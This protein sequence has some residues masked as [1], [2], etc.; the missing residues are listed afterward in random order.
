MVVRNRVEPV[1]HVFKQGKRRHKLL[2]IDIGAHQ[3]TER[4]SFSSFQL[5]RHR[6][7][8]GQQPRAELRVA[9]IFDGFLFAARAVAVDL[10]DVVA[11]LAALGGLVGLCE[12]AVALARL[13]RLGVGWRRIVRGWN[14]VARV[15]LLAGVRAWSFATSVLDR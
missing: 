5:L 9:Q 3:C 11:A 8:H 4:P 12:L 1:G 15:R 2:Y 13:A 10:G 14:G 6:A 7:G